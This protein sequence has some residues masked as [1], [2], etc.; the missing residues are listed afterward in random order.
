MNDIENRLLGLR[1]ALMERRVRLIESIRSIRSEIEGIDR[2]LSDCSSA[3]RVFNLKWPEQ[4]LHKEHEPLREIILPHLQEAGTV[5][6]TVREL[7]PIV[8]RELGR[9]FHPKTF[10]MTLFRMKAAGDVERTGHVWKAK[11]A[12]DIDYDK[13]RDM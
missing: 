4:I 7:R 12:T 8:E 11:P 13:H 9:K 6:I 2:Q 10:G 5:G 3:A 1:D